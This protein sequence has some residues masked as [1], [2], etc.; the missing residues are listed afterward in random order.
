MSGYRNV[1]RIAL[2]WI[3]SLSLSA[4]L[5]D[6]GAGWNGSSSGSASSEGVSLAITN[7]TSASAMDTTDRTISLAGT[8][9]S[10]LGIAEVSWRNDRG[11]Q[12]TA[13]GTSN[14]QASSVALQLGQ[15]AITVTAEDG[16]GNTQ[17]RNITVNRESGETG[18][19]TLSWIAPTTREDGSALTNLAGY[20]IYYGRMS[21]T[22]DYTVEI[23][24]P[25]VQT[26]VVEELVS[27]DWYFVLSAYDSSDVESNPSN[28]VS[29]TIS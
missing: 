19:A 23:S 20:K 3:L 25:G 21:G 29:R 10:D 13:S 16:G 27:G 7:P 2:V 18:S 22:Y 17:S 28:E 6:S 14:W 12:G 26:Y 5:L 1:A 11:G 8:A 24:N 9:A 15:N 4:C